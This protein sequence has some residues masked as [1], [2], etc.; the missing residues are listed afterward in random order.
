M[1]SARKRSAALLI[2]VNYLTGRDTQGNGGVSDGTL[3]DREEVVVKHDQF[4]SC[5]MRVHAV[6]GLRAID[7]G[8]P[9][10]EGFD[11]CRH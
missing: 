1:F 10:G 2:A 5:A 8:D 3:V 6:V 9:A 7:Q 11:G 4:R